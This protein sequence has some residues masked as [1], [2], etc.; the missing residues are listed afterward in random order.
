MIIIAGKWHQLADD[1]RG[2]SG[3]LAALTGWLADSSHSAWSF[4]LMCQFVKTPK[5]QTY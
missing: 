5:L 2:L 1:P 4:Q 3:H